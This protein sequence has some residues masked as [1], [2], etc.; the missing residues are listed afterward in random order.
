MRPE[1]RRVQGSPA[2][3]VVQ[4][5]MRNKKTQPQSTQRPQSVF[6]Q[7]NKKHESFYPYS[8]FSAS[9]RLSAV[10]DSFL[11]LGDRTLFFSESSGDEDKRMSEEEAESAEIILRKTFGVFDL[12]GSVGN[13]AA[14]PPAS[15]PRALAYFNLCVVCDLCG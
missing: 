6:F 7:K 3:N 11:L 13:G 9:S 15:R 1:P 12:P 10:C 8:I 14:F 4:G 2:L 5:G